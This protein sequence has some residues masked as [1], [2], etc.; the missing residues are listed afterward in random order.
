SK[1][2]QVEDGRQ[3][4]I[5]YKEFFTLCEQLGL[6]EFLTE[7]PP[8]VLARLKRGMLRSTAARKIG[9]TI[10]TLYNA[11]AGFLVSD[12]TL[13]KIYDFWESAEEKV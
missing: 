4:N 6:D 13:K 2:A 1:L 9:V 8:L 10:Q 12:E 3:C 5:K 11:E 7:L